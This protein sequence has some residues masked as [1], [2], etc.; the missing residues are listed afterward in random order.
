[1]MS[2]DW[3]SETHDQRRHQKLKKTWELKATGQKKGVPH[4]ADCDSKRFGQLTVDAKLK[5]G[6]SLRRIVVFQLKKSFS[7]GASLCFNL[8]MFFYWLP[9]TRD[10]KRH[11]K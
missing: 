10:Q 7:C 8:T 3:L 1:M 9:G 4:F 11:Q 5:E 2:S 6:L